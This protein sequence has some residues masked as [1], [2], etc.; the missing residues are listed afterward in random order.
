[1]CTPNAQLA[2][3]YNELWTYVY[4]TVKVIRNGS[5]SQRL[6]SRYKLLIRDVNK[7][8]HAPCTIFW[9]SRVGFFH[10]KVRLLWILMAH[11]PGALTFDW[12]S[13]CCRW[14]GLRESC[15]Q[16]WLIWLMVLIV[17]RERSDQFCSEVHHRA[18]VFGGR[19]WEPVLDEILINIT[20][21]GLSNQPCPWSYNLTLIWVTQFIK[22]SG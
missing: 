7:Q 18:P 11:R 19:F 15:R 1:M 13:V 16:M 5:F 17:T 8:Q 3:K 21:S 14:F 6:L 10:I 20:S 22:T 12:S 2:L 9:I 4:W